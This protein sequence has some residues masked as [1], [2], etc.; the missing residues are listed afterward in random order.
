[1]ESGCVFQD[2]ESF[3]CNRVPSAYYAD[4]LVGTHNR[5]NQA[6]HRSF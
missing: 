2:S 3:G 1:L 5:G 4:C 6:G